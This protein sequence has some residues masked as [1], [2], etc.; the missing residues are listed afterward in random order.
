MFTSLLITKYPLKQACT[1]GLRG[2]LCLLQYEGLARLCRLAQPRML[3][4]ITVFQWYARSTMIDSHRIYPQMR[5]KGTTF[6]FGHQIFRQ[7][8]GNYF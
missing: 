1:A 3:I 2:I 6:I 4:T 7:L 8:F 5:C